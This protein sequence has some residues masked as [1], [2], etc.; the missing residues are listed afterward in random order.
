MRGSATAKNNSDSIITSMP[1]SSIMTQSSYETTS[2][3]GRDF[4][5]DS[6]AFDNLYASRRLSTCGTVYD[7]FSAPR[8]LSK[9]S[10]LWKQQIISKRERSDK[11]GCAE[12]FSSGRK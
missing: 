9:D 8:R 11:C 12:T 5:A 10:D 1:D 3:G 6:S 2:T 7:G 4:E